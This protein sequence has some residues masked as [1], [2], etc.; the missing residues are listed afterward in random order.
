MFSFRPIAM[1]LAVAVCFS[2]CSS[3]TPN[4]STDAT[5]GRH[6]WT[7]P[8]TLRIADASE[9]ASLNP[10]LQASQ[11]ETDLNRLS[12]DVLISADE[13]GEP[14]PMLAADVPTTA[15]GGISADGR[16]IVYHLRKNVKWH[17]GKPFTS[18]DV[19]FTFHAIMNSANN[20][21]SR[22]GYREVDR[23]ETPDAFTVR[24]HLRKKY[25]PFVTTV[26]GE[27]DAV[28]C[29]LPAHLL[30]GLPDI[31]HVPFNSAPIGTG[32]FKVV[33][34]QRG[35]HIEYVRNDDY[36]LGKPGIEKVTVKFV[37]DT[38]TEYV[39][40][41]THEVD[42]ILEAT[43]RSVPQLRG[44]TEARL[45]QPHSN[46]YLS[47]GFNTTHPIVSDV[48]VRR[49]ISAAVD[50]V[51]INHDILHDSF[52]LAVAD[53]PSF[54]WAFDPKL[55]APKYDL[56][57]AKS[58]LASA[59]IT[60]DH[61]VRLAFSTLA[62]NATDAGLVVQ[63]QAALKPLGIDIENHAFAGPLYF[64]SAQNGGILYGGKF[65]MV[66]SSWLSGTDPDDSSLYSCDQ[67]PPKG[68]AITRY[69]SKEMDAAQ[70]LALSSY[71]RT[72][73]KAAYSKIES[74]LLRDVPNIFISS[75]GTNEAIS[76]DFKNFAPNPVTPMANAYRWSI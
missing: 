21:V 31:N 33:N 51:K 3:T 40:L 45:V 68:N 7:I 23:I 74:L 72:I 52:P 71:D 24:F 22:N 15:N 49:G 32:P 9:P 62:G 5:T 61:R 18:E 13:R 42:W 64:A 17:D 36:F 76:I 38:N 16:T 43:N 19:A 75:A 50:R 41:R 66:T 59:G 29:I 73:R 25:A 35:D 28:Y 6:S 65:D 56:D 63:V 39:Q 53:L 37:P 70:K 1:A 30:K 54:M 12:F 10:L 48:R 58:L 67:V 2:A 27:S 34:W 14:T 60:P 20:V 26:F 46:G 55:T 47:I 57:Q 8:N 11:F 4:T 44:L 69:C